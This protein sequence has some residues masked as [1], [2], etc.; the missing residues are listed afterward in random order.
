M[1]LSHKLVLL[2][3]FNIDFLQSPL[4]SFC[5]KLLSVVTSFNLN[6]IVS[7]ATHVTDASSTLLIDLIFVSSPILMLS[8]VKQSPTL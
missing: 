5:H 1:S 3:D 8:F 4:S 6:Q 2:G 7:Q